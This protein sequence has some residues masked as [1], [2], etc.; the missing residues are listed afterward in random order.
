MISC[1]P[2]AFREFKVY[3]KTRQGQDWMSLLT[4]TQCAVFF[5]DF[6]TA[7]PLSRDGVVYD[8]MT[9][10]TFLVFDR[11][12]EAQRFCE[13]QVKEH[14]SMCCEV[15]DFEGK[16]K[17]PLLVVVNPSVAEKDELSAS[18]V[19]RRKIIAI[20][21]FL[22]AIPLLVWDWRTG[23]YLIVPTVVGI[24]LIVFG[25]RLLYWNAARSDRS[26]EQSHRL[27]SH[28]RREAESGRKSE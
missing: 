10:C 27:E 17:P 14:P 22:G 20:A 13:A 5:K 23:S 7:A 4:P 8:K 28:R 25:L 21:S 3:D 1:Q 6:Q 16:A 2:G 19:R 24:N 26:Q 15:F 9:D 11:L 18:W 12:E